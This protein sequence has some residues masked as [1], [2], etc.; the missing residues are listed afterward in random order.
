MMSSNAAT[1]M[2]VCVLIG[3]AEVLKSIIVGLIPAVCAFN[4]W[5]LPLWADEWAVSKFCI[6]L[7]LKYRNS[8]FHVYT[9][10]FKNFNILRS[11]AVFPSTIP[12]TGIKHSNF[13]RSCFKML[14]SS[15]SSTY[16]GVIHCPFLNL[17]NNYCPLFRLQELI[18]TAGTCF[19]CPMLTIWN[20]KYL[21]SRSQ[22]HSST[23]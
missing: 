11:I 22:I 8:V 2:S 16:P 6:C 12:N 19:F 9:W 1:L 17:P 4:A 21:Q 18:P 13:S 15:S 20:H 10:H 5:V 14:Y 7:R 3:F 23:H